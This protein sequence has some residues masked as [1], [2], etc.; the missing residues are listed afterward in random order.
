MTQ[1][2]P[3]FPRQNARPYDVVDP[4]GG[5]VAKRVTLAEADAMARAM[6]ATLASVRP[7]SGV[8]RLLR[9]EVDA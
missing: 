5:L 3:I 6:G 7:E 1:V 8:V 2:H 4:D 9:V